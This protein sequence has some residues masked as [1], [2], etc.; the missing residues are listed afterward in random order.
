MELLMLSALIFAVGMIW[1]VINLIIGIFRLFTMEKENCV[2]CGKPFR[3]F[4]L[5]IKPLCK[6]CK[7]EYKKALIAEIKKQS[8]TARC[9]KCDGTGKIKEYKC[10]KCNGKGFT[11]R[12][13]SNIFQSAEGALKD[14]PMWKDFFETSA[15]QKP[16]HVQTTFV[17]KMFANNPERIKQ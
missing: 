16:S 10:A 6:K 1:F 17:E 2:R 7:R 13:E 15:T 5:S 11:K 4:A 12:D 3:C 14:N 9:G 8:A